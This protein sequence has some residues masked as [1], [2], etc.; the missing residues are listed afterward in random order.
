[1]CKF[2]T[3]HAN[4]VE[5]RGMVAGAWQDGTY[6]VDRIHHAV[7]AEDGSVILSGSTSEDPFDKA[8]HGHDVSIAVK[9][10][11]DGTEVWRWKVSLRLRAWFCWT[12]RP[13][14]LRR[15]S[16]HVP[17]PT[18][19]VAERRKESIP[20]ARSSVISRPRLLLP[21]VVFVLRFV[22]YGPES[23]ARDPSSCVAYLGR[24]F[25][26]AK[27]MFGLGRLVLRRSHGHDL[28]RP[29]SRATRM[30]RGST[31]HPV[32]PTFLH[33]WSTKFLRRCML[34]WT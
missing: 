15:R 30:A 9:I 14:V 12:R 21:A 1:M 13:L 17:P 7:A 25:A 33:V 6:G 29:I 27:L 8:S 19:H 4:N 3:L 11:A 28:N 2:C 5:P 24:D 20:L 34:V 22:S 26:T 18:N 31:R 16:C 32:A 23:S 10:D